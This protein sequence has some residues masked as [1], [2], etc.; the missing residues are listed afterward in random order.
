MERDVANILPT[1]LWTVIFQMLSGNEIR[2]MRLVNKQFHH[3]TQP[4]FW[5]SLKLCSLNSGAEEKARTIIRNPHL[6]AYTRHLILQPSSWAH[7]V[8]PTTW[9][10]TNLW[11]RNYSRRNILDRFRID[12]VDW[13][14]PTS[15][16]QI[17]RRSRKSIQT[18]INAI[19]LLPNLLKLTI[20][21]DFFMEPRPNPEPYRKL[22][23]GLKASQLRCLCL[24]FRSGSSVQVIADAIRSVTQAVGAS[25]VRGKGSTSTTSRSSLVFQQLEMLDLNVSTAPNGYSVVDDFARDIQTIVDLGRSSIQSLRI[26]YFATQF[27]DWAQPYLEAFFGGLGLFPRLQHIDY[28]TLGNYNYECFKR[29]LTRHSS[30]VVRLRLTGIQERLFSLATF[31]PKASWLNPEKDQISDTRPLFKFTHLALMVQKGYFLFPPLTLDLSRFA[32]TLTTLVLSEIGWKY[33]RGHGYTYQDIEFLIRSLERPLHSGVLLERFCLSIATLSPE[34]FDLMAEYL[35]NL[36]DLEL[37]YAVLVDHKDQGETKGSETLFLQR[38]EA[39]EY[40]N[41]CLQSIQIYAFPQQK[42]VHNVQLMGL[43]AAKI[44]SIRKR[45]K[46]DWSDVCIRFDSYL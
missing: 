32:D 20:F 40:P 1:E 25:S 43:L 27:G 13:D 21:M 34:L 2:A 26:L 10:P 19:S 29:F 36:R 39:R 44:P 30:T 11:V 17:F 18:A 41:W 22:W 35:V 5:K 31:K 23:S 7:P 37:R 24:T 6:G 33:A 14:H 12:W 42:P 38:M 4:F 45:G 15:S 16:F 3:L 28:R 46:I 9:V 8:G